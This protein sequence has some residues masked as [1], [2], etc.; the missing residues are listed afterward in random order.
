VADVFEEVEEQLRSERYKTLARKGWPYAVAVILAVLIGFGGV[1]AWRSYQESLSAKASEGY[2]RALEAGSRGDRAA[3]ER[4]FL[5]VSKSGPRAYRALALMQVAGLRLEAGKT[6]EG[7]T[8]L[9]QAADLAPEPLVADAARLK[10]AYAVFE[11]ASLADLRNRLD[12]LTEAGRPYAALAR[13]AVAMKQLASGDAAAA[14]TTFSALSLLPDATDELRQ[15]AQAAVLL[16][17]SGASSVIP[18]A[19]RAAAALPDPPPPSATLAPAAPPAGAA[20]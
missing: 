14:R 12:P 15:R 13:E 8:L 16:I 6:A 4:G 2:S 10:A 18:Q 19:A 1:W 9:E 7:V 11:T 5:E 3:A 17:D 20:Q